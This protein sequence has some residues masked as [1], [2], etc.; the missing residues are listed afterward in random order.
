M[1]KQKQKKSFFLFQ[2]TLKITVTFFG[3]TILLFNLIGSQTISQLFQQIVNEERNAVSVFL[4]K[5]RYTPIFASE[6]NR[7]KNVYGEILEKEVFSE[8]IYRK[9]E[10]AKYE[11]MLLQN[12]DAKEVHYQLFVLYKQIGK[13]AKANTHY[14]KAVQIDPEL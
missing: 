13:E 1:I 3:G 12:P 2:K 6:Y 14:Q 8:E 10:I 11:K 9:N 7:L 5:V 4:K